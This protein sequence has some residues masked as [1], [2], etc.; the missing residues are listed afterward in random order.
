MLEE[1]VGA[2]VA[3][4]ILRDIDSNK[5][6]KIQYSEFLAAAND[7]LY[8]EDDDM[9]H[10]AFVALDA[11]GDEYISKDEIIDGLISS[12][13]MFSKYKKQFQQMLDEMYQEYGKK[14]EERDIKLNEAEFS[15]M[16]KDRFMKLE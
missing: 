3:N 10:E 13:E 2:I 5:D 11:D 4:K 1:E 16:I 9:I 14:D 12:S 8:D 7:T 6:G 15:E